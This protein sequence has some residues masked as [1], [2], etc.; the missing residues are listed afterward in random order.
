MRRSTALQTTT[1]AL[2]M[3]KM[4]T[5]APWTKFSAAY[6]EK[7]GASDR[8]ALLVLLLDMVGAVVS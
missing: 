6:C 4:A 1:L 8:G 7:I 2:A 5:P 3:W